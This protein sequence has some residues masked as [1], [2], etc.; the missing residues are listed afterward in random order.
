L[1]HAFSEKALR[2]QE[3][4]INQYFDLFISKLQENAGQPQDMVSWFNFV[5]FDIIGDLT[6]GESFDCLKEAALH[7]WV[8]LLFKFFKAS[9]ILVTARRFPWMNATIIPLMIPKSA[10]AARGEHIIFTKNKVLSRIERG[11][12]RPDFMSG[13]LKH[14]DKEARLDYL[15]NFYKIANE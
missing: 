6:L 10:V 12:Y 5:S 9:A 4:L 11:T 3:P 15:F 8:E 13:I 14:N 7:P 2:E 1:S